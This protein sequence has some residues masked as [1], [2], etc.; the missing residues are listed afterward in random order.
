MVPRILCKASSLATSK[1]SWGIS[2]NYEKKEGGKIFFRNA[3]F[4]EVDCDSVPLL[5]AWT[6]L[7]PGVCPYC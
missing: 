5:I 3:H 2:D 4:P 6:V 7:D 1:F